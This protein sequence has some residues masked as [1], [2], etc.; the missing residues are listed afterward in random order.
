MT[1]PTQ[2]NCMNHV[3]LAWSL[4]LSCSLLPFA[5]P[6]HAGTVLEI[7]DRNLANKSESQARTYAQAGKMRIESGGP[8][9]SFAIF[10]DET[11]YTFDPKQKTYVAMDRATIKRLAEQLNPALKLLQEQLA[12][13]PPE[14]RAQ[15]ER[16]LGIKLPDSKQSPEEV[17][18]TA[19]TATIAGHACKISEIVQD[20]VV[21]AEACV[22]PAADL[23]GGKE[24]FEVAI[25]VSTLLKDMVD[26][27]DLP[28]L[29]QM[30]SRQMENFDRLG[31]VPVL[32]RT[33]DQGQP[34]QE[35][36]MK[37]IRSEPLADNL[38]AIPADYKQQ[39]MSKLSP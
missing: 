33:F 14:Q 16:S 21:Q 1:S 2:E 5:H 22:V 24:L 39:D 29:K 36:T 11:I 3:T 20:G 26:S 12:N 37:S 10:R 19:R 17:R 27:I 35:T 4:V 18:K 7:T 8:Q 31:G 34:I 38:F 6:L 15:M 28:M 32:T 13:M 30:A 9:D 25:K 23:Q